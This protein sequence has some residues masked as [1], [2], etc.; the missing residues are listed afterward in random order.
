MLTCFLFFGRV[1]FEVIFLGVVF[2]RMGTP[3]VIG[4]VYKLPAAAS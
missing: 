3:P 1:F 4:R 2:F